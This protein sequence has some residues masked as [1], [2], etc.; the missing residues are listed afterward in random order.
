MIRL[1]PR[2][3]LTGTLFPYTTLF[4]S[5]QLAYAIAFFLRYGLEYGRVAPKKNKAYLAGLDC[6]EI[7]ALARAFVHERLESRLRPALLTRLDRHRAAGHRIALLTGT[8]DFIAAPLADRIEADIWRATRCG[9]RGGK[10][11]ADPPDMHPFAETKLRH[12]LGICALMGIDLA[13]CTAYAD[14]AYDL[15]LLERVARPVPLQPG[16][17]RKSAEE[18]KRGA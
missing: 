2:S 15:P 14:S 18:G 1:P 12:A 16:P 11:C 6:S 10:F 8:P 7:A 3:T 13:V 4:L 17:D 5:L 9:Q